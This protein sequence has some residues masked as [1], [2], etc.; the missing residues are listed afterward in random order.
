[1]SSD[2]L[3]IYHLAGTC[4]GRMKLYYDAAGIRRQLAR[5]PAQ[6]ELF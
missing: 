4:I 1:V 2:L 5:A 3:L 6:G